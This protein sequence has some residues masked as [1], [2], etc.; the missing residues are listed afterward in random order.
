MDDRQLVLAFMSQHQLMVIST[1]DRDS[2]P[3]SA[4]VGF[5]E[6]D[7][8]EIIFGTSD[9]SRKAKNLETNPYVSLVIGWDKLGTLQ[10]EGE[11]SLLTGSDIDR[12]SAIYFS[13]NPYA[14]RLKDN[15]EEVYFFIK[16]SWIRLTETDKRPRV[17]RELIF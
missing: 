5:G 15:P 17:I 3:Q 1:L 8:L 16:P 6:T 13:K 2:K 7:S 11:A 9:K 4:V 12:Y 10:Y 14:E